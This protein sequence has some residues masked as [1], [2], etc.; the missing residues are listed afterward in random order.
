MKKRNTFKCQIEYNENGNVKVTSY[1]N[2][3]IHPHL[4][5]LLN[6]SVHEAREKFN[7]EAEWKEYFI[8][9]THDNVSY[10]QVKRNGIMPCEGCI[11]LKG[12]CGCQHP[13]YLDGAKGNC[14]NKIYVK[15]L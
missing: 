8:H 7:N 11:F 10:K 12:E 5:K 3:Q 6:E 2:K 14:N 9:F 15:E 4:F 1:R 13:H